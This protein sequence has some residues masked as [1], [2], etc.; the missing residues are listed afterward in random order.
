MRVL[1]ANLVVEARVEL[2]WRAVILLAGSSRRPELAVTGRSSLDLPLGDGSNVLDRLIGELSATLGEGLGTTDVRL[3]VG[4]GQGE[5]KQ[6]SPE[7][8]GRSVGW[9]SVERDN[10]PFRGTGGAVADAAR[11]YGDNDLILVLQAAQVNFTPLCK[12]AG[13]LLRRVEDDGSDVVVATN[14]AGV[15]EGAILMRVGAL[16]GL[17]KEG[18]VDLKEQAL[19]ALAKEFRVTVLKGSGQSSVP[20]RTATD[21]LRAVALTSV[22]GG[23]RVGNAL[24]DLDPGRSGGFK[25]I[26]EGAKV[27]AGARVVDS[28][29]LSG[30]TVESGAVVVRSVVGGGVTVRGASAYVDRLAGAEGGAS[31]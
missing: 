12:T 10:N 1:E 15:P 28:V 7:P 27:A 5:G 23:V 14:S 11:G 21:Y 9:L 13:A 20:V 26:E 24:W 31:Q 2:K 30:A 25:L 8:A 4:H 16:R 3:L 6:F 18:F 22:V 29:V 17:K 19:P